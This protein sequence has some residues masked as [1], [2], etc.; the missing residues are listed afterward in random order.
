MANTPA[1]DILNQEHQDYY[2]WRDQ[3]S[4]AQYT[5]CKYDGGLEQITLELVPDIILEEVEDAYH[6]WADQYD[7]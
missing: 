7:Q 5:G 1:I 3:Q 4:I 6:Q 2:E